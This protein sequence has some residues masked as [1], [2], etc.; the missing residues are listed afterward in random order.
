M[1]IYSINC[2]N[3]GSTANIDFDNPQSFCGSCGSKIMLDINQIKDLLMAKELTKQE[4]EKTRRET[5]KTRREVEKTRREE[6]KTKRKIEHERFI[7]KQ[8]EAANKQ[9]PFFIIGLTLQ[10]LIIVFILLLAN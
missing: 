10:M 6:E 3:C 1:K 5:E 9:L 2:P 4:V 8:S 7:L